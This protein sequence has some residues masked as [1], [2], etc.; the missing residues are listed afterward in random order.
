MT[1]AWPSLPFVVA[2]SLSG[3]VGPPP[4][5]A[6]HSHIERSCGT[7]AD[8]KLVHE[9][10]CSR[11]RCPE[12]VRDLRTSKRQS[13]QTNTHPSPRRPVGGSLAACG[14]LLANR[15]IVLYNFCCHLDT[16]QYCM[17][18]IIPVAP[19]ITVSRAA[20]LQRVEWRSTRPPS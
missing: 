12:P 6:V 18:Q 13:E 19:S 20:A 2:G 5:R 1:D 11:C 15:Y 10:P 17:S 4:M 8:G 16:V 7:R 3:R 14:T 9:L